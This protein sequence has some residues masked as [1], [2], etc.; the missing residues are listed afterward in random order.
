M[1]KVRWIVALA[2]C[3][4]LL[5]QPVWADDDDDDEGFFSRFSMRSQPQNQTYQNECASCHMAYQA[6]LLPA[7]S[8]QKLMQPQALADHFGDNAELDEADRQEILAFL[9]AHASDRGR[10]WIRARGGEAPLRITELSYFKRE[11]RELPKRM[12]QGNPKVRSLS[13]CQACHTGAARGD[14]GERGIR[15]PGFGYWED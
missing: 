7:A 14:Y 3:L 11:H 1:L 12:V 9:L 15:I 8:W 4:P 10:A 13:N 2:V 6:G 5:T